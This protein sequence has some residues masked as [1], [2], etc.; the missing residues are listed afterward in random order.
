MSNG[1]VECGWF[2]VQIQKLTNESAET[3]KWPTTQGALVAGVSPNSPAALAG[4]EVGDV[5]LAFGDQAVGELKDL[6]KLVANTAPGQVTKV[7]VWRQG[8]QQ[9]FEVSV[10]R[11]TPITAEAKAVTS[12]AVEGPRLGLA[13]APVTEALRQRFDLPPNIDGARVVGI[14]SGYLL[15]HA[16]GSLHGRSVEEVS[17]AGKPKPSLLSRTVKRAGQNV[18]LQPLEFRLLEHLVR[19]AGQVVTRTMLFKNVWD[20]R[21]GPQTNV[22]DVHVSRLRGKLDKPFSYPP[23]SHHPRRSLYAS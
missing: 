13:L 14:E 10:A 3:L 6:P 1:Q 21:F 11:S 23:P 8:K 2:G 12:E 16:R 18:E 17:L 5:I 15:T 19:H 22:I 4:T 7:T 9:D 20:Y